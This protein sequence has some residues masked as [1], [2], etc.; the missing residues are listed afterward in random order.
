MINILSHRGYWK[1]ESEKNSELA[2][3]RSFSLGFGTE[4]DIRDF[5]GELV[6]SHDIA[7][8][9]CLSVDFFFRLYKSINDNLPLALNIKSDGLQIKLLEL[10]N[11]YD[12]KNYFVFDMSVPD[13]LNY[14][15]NDFNVFTRQSEYELQPSFYEE[16]KG[17]WLDEFKDHWISKEILK[18]HLGNNKS[19]CIVSPDLHKRH[20][21]KE[22]NNYKEYNTEMNFNNWMICTDFPEEAKIFFYE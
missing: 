2:F 15:K 3:K 9:E 16:A 17:V 10:L 18:E 19:V 4:T 20:Y 12:I 13:G 21:L 11:K 6:I 7:S 14:L 1:K 8:V 22:W 5:N